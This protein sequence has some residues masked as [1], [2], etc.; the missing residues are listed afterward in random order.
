[1]KVICD[2]DAK[3]HELNA[4]ERPCKN[5]TSRYA[6]WQPCPEDKRHNAEWYPMRD[7]SNDPRWYVRCRDCN[8]EGYVKPTWP[9]Y[10]EN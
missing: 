1:M 9:L 2:H 4:D 8:I 3:P 7:I 6:Q 5:P 10:E